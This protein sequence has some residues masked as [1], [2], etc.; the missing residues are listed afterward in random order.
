MHGPFVAF[1]GIGNM[2]WPMAAR[3]ERAGFALGV[4]DAS[5]ERAERFATE[6][7]VSCAPLSE[8]TARCDVLVTMLP[9]S[10]IVEQVLFGE[11]GASDRLRP[12][13]CSSR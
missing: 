5:S 6:H 3:I 12:A 8:L 4:A 7:R 13:R 10:D 1:V 9:T 2:G 11:S